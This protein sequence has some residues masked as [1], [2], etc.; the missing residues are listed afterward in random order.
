MMDTPVPPTTRFRYWITFVDRANP[1]GTCDR[2]REELRTWITDRG[3]GYGM[4]ALGGDR[5]IYGDI[6]FA[7]PATE[8]DRQALTAWLRTRRMCA[9]VQLGQVFDGDY[10]LMDP[11]IGLAFAVDG[12]TG[13]DRCEAAAYYEDLRRWS[14]EQRK[15]AG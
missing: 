1:P 15:P 5:N 14:E 8:A 10:S 7:P 6:G 13:E 9:D 3:L 4:G 2:I 12:L 11:I